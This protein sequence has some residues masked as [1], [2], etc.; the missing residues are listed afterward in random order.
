MSPKVFLVDSKAEFMA[1]SEVM[2]ATK[3]MTWTPGCLASTEFL[4]ER[5]EEAVRP[6]MAI[7]VEPEVAKAWVMWGPIPAG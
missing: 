7:L 4:V 2:S 6:I 3:V 1:A 5:R